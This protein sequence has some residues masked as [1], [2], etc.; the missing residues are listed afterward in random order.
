MGEV[1]MFS[2]QIGDICTSWKGQKTSQA[3]LTN[4]DYLLDVFKYISSFQSTLGKV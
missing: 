1:L 3:A 4:Y 2:L